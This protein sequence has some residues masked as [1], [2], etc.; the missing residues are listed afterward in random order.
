MTQGVTLNGFL[1]KGN[2]SGFNPNWFFGEG[3]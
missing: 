3:K 2:D 1:A